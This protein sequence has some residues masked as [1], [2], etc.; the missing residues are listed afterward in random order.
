MT[1]IELLD[2]KEFN[3]R[4]SSKVDFSTKID[5]FG[6]KMNKS[7]YD[8]FRKKENLELYKAIY[9]EITFKV[10]ETKKNNFPF[11]LYAK[12]IRKRNIIS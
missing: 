11:V 9:K 12:K 3:K 1:V 2:I 6:E 7:L 8:W 4:I 5:G 10:E